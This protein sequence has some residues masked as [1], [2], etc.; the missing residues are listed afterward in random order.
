M[1]FHR[2]RGINKKKQA[3]NQQYEAEYVYRI[4]L[5]GNGFLYDT[6]WTDMAAPG[7]VM[8]EKIH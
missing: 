8:W 7:L 6:L 3:Y 1:N 4:N 5:L 2:K